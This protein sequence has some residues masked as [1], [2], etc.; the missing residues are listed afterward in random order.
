M[1]KISF[2]LIGAGRAGMVHA[3]NIVRTIENARLTAI[4]DSSREALDQRG[5]ELG[6]S[7]LYSSVDEA[8]SEGS[9]DAVVVVTPTFTHRDIVVKCAEA[10]KHIFCEKPMSITVEEADDMINAASESGVKLQ[11]G[12]MRRFDEPFVRAHDIIADG[13]L[14]CRD[15][16]DLLPAIGLQPASRRGQPGAGHDLPADLTDDE[17]LVLEAVPFTPEPVPGV[18]RTVSL[19]LTTV[20]TALGRLEQLDLVESPTPATVVRVGP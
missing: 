7:E 3:N 11:V 6:V 10:G 12:F 9:F 13:A 14:V 16:H 4:V 8:L 20:L 19:P 17:R 1:E 5:E 15:V 18:A 2:C